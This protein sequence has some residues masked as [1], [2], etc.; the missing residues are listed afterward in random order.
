MSAWSTG[1]A[2]PVCGR[3]VE[4]APWLTCAKPSPMSPAERCAAALPDEEAP[5]G[6]GVLDRPADSV[7]VALRAAQT[8]C[9]A[10][11]GSCVLLLMSRTGRSLPFPRLRRWQRG[12]VEA[13][14]TQGMYQF[15]YTTLLPVPRLGSLFCPLFGE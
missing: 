5:S 12:G 13:E 6:S 7:E 4:V 1:R 15:T 10:S 9:T 2:C 3:A 11:S 8:A 14:R